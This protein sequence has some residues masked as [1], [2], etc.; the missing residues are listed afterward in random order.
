M[1]VLLI[2]G[3]VFA[4]SLL[5]SVIQMLALAALLTFVLFVPARSLTR[6]LRLP[7]ALSVILIY[8]VLSLVIVFGI[9]LVIPSAIDG[10]QN[11]SN[12]LIDSLSGLE[13]DLQPYLQEGRNSVEVLGVQVD[14][15]FILD[16]VRQALAA[17]TQMDDPAFDS[18]ATESGAVTISSNDL[19]TLVNSLLSLVGTLTETLT[20]AVSSIAGLITS[21]FLAILISFFLLLDV[22][23]MSRSIMRWIPPN[24]NREYA[25]LVSKIVRVW[26]G[27]FKGQ[28]IIGVMIGILTFVQL[29]MMGV[30]N[31]PLLAALTG[32]ISLI[33][34]IG[35][36]LALIPLGLVPLIN[37][38]SVFV[39]MPYGLFALFVIGVN[40]VIS[41]I[42]WNVIAPKILGDVLDL[43]LVLIIVG[44]FIGAAVGGLLG[45]FLVAPIMGTIRILLLYIVAK[46]GMYDPYPGEP[47]PFI[48][49]DPGFL[50][51]QHLEIDEEDDINETSIVVQN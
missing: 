39:G 18:T 5:G 42:I 45:A 2:V 36:F 13:D 21:A 12:G 20:S 46:I 50:R 38:S 33:P 4:L 3:A 35:G 48:L 43:P 10:V 6:R 24:F 22:P 25:L 47:A 41:Q 26:N 19:R 16:P 31:A 49:G 27:F 34:T 30:S 40:L 37:G 1:T 17:V 7:W 9:L 29:Q 32:T 28:V 51:S 8:F 14:I 44:V 15:Q 23:G 11:I